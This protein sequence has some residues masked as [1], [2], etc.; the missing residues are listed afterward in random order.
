YFAKAACKGHKGA[1]EKLSMCYRLGHGVPQ[2][3][4]KSN[5]YKTRAECA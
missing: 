5:E 2:D 3:M 1:L 4:T